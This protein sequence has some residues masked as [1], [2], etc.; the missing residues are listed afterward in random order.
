MHEEESDGLSRLAGGPRTRARSDCPI[1]DKLALLAAGLETEGQRD[2]LLEHI[3]GCDACGAIFRGMVEDFADE[4]SE[5]ET[6]LLESL[7]SSRAV[8]QKA[9]ARRMAGESRGRRVIMFPTWLARAAAVLLALGGS[10][11]LAWD[12]WIAND[13]ARLLAKAYTARRPFGYRIPGA[14]YAVL[15]PQER[16]GNSVFGRAQA[17]DEA[18]IR[19]KVRLERNPEDVKTLELLARGELMEGD[20]EDAFG[21]LQRALEHKPDDPDLLADLGMAYALR[22]GKLADRDVDFGY[23]MDYLLRSLRAKPKSPE[24]IFNLALVYE[25]MSMVE[26]AIDAWREYLT[27]DPSGSWHE[28]A[29]ISLSRLEQKKKSERQ[30]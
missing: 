1:V 26:K 24:T 21:T 5:A 13:P 16:S 28:E 4:W 25:K 18:S 3:S 30:P 20:L 29:Q 23:A 17:L 2:M 14:E 8:R 19:I 6:R 15:A 27:L 7:Q 22:A 10:G 9:M 12:H 11:W